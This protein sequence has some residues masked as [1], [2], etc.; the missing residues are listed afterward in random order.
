MFKEPNL[1]RYKKLG[2]RDNQ[3]RGSDDIDSGVENDEDCGTD[4]IDS[5]AS[6]AIDGV[7]TNDKMDLAEEVCWNARGVA[8]TKF[9]TNMLDL[10]CSQHLDIVF[11]CEPWISGV[12]A[13]SIVKSL[14]LPCFEIVGPMG[15][16]GWLWLLWNDQKVHV[17][18]IGTHDQVIAACVSWPGMDPWLFS[19]VYAK[20]CGVKSEKLWEYLGFVVDCHFLPWLIVG[21][22][23]KMLQIEDKIEEVAACRLKGFKKWFDDHAMVDL[24]FS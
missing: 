14:S 1:C 21:D 5:L 12:K 9:I 15:F 20:P 18:I 11:V 3:R 23:N 10:I 8:S 7:F 4:D 17:E 19:A 6:S 2:Q 13:S 22:F 16:C 24:G